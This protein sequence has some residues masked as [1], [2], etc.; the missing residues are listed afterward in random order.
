M[1]DRTANLNLPYIMPNQAQKHVTHNEAIRT[2]DALVQLAVRGRSRTAPPASPSDGERYIVAPG[3]GGTWLGWDGSVA[4]FVDGAWARL[5]P[6]AGWQSWVQD[7]GRMLVWSG[8]AWIAGASGQEPEPEASFESLGIG[9]TADPANPFSVKLNSALFSARGDAEGGSGDVSAAF[10][11]E[12][13]GDTSAISFQVSYSPRA[14]LGLL[15]NDDFSI[16]V[17]PNGVDYTPAL[18]IDRNTGNVAIGAGTDAGNRLVVSGRN[19]LFTSDT[20]FNVVMNKGA[21]GGDLSFAFQTGY[22]AQALMGLLGGNDFSVKVGP[23]YRTALSIQ[24]PSGAVHH[25][26]NPKFSAYLTGAQ[27][28]DANVWQTLQFDALRHDV[29]ERFDLAAHAFDAPVSGCYVFG[30][31]AVYSALSS[32]PSVMRLGFSVNGSD[33]TNDRTRRQGD[34]A[35]VSGETSVGLTSL[36]ALQAGDRVSA[37]VRYTGSAANVGGS[38]TAYFWGAMLA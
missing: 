3:S 22:Q 27:F 24:N 2:L 23:D 18:A 1:S 6:Q 29:G 4:C 13:S 26:R 9:T 36:I 35:M 15:S 16:S 12:A 21:A 19:A 28:V 34:A 17:S 33:P 11:K 8:T 10:S 25:P 31:T 38:E 37:V 7:E 32:A 20:D 14:V 5:V 30:A